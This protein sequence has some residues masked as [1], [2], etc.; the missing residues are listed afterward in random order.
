MRTTGIRLIPRD[1]AEI[2]ALVARARLE[3]RALRVIGAGHSETAAIQAP[4]QPGRPAPLLLGLDYLDHVEFDPERME[5]QVGGGCRLGFD[6]GDPLGRSSPERGLCAQLDARGWALPALAGVT[7]QTLA[8]YLATGS[9]TGSLRHSLTSAVVGLRLVDGQG[10][11]L[12]LERGRDEAFDAALVSLGLL[13]IVTEVRLRCEPRYA[14][15]GSEVIVARE[16]APFDLF[17]KAPR[18]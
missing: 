13:G 9:A 17:A 15:R 7:H 1:E 4:N 5:V 2:V 12:E 6:P 11:I 10:R 16:D 8:G 14:S 18:A 3:G